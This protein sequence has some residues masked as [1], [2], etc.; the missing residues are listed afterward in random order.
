MEGQLKLPRLL[1]EGCVLQQGEKTRVWGWCRRNALVTVTLNG[2]RE[3]AYGD[4]GGGFEVFFRDLC[5]GGPYSLR[6]D[7]DQEDFLEVKTLWV[8]EVFVCGGQSNM[9]L[10]MRRV[11]ERFPEELLHGGDPEV[12]IYKVMETSEFSVPLCDHNDARWVVCRRDELEELSAVS[13]YLGKYL[14]Q[15][16]KVPIGIINLSLGG[17]PAEAWTSPEGLKEFGELLA[18][19]KKYEDHTFR[20]T[21]LNQQKEREQEWYDLLEKQEG[22]SRSAPWRPFRLPGCLCDI[23]LMAFSGCVWLKRE[24]FVP[25]ELAG[26]PC[27]LKFG[28]MA[29]SDTI[30]INGKLVGETG[31]R[32]PPR[33][34]QVPEG[35]LKA[36]KN[37]ICLRLVC[38]EGDGRITPGKQ[39]CLQWDQPQQKPDPDPGRAKGAAL[40]DTSCGTPSRI[41][42]TGLW[43]CQVRAVCSPAPKPEFFNRRPTGL[44]HGMVSPCL[45]YTVKGVVWYQGESNDSRPVLY[46][47]LLKA[48]I[49]DWRSQW[50]Q[51]NLPFVLVQLPC[52]G[53]DIAPYP[54]WPHIREAQ[55]KAGQLPMT[56][57][58]VNLDLG[59]ENDLHPL[60]KKNVAYRIFLAIQR[61]FY[62]E[63]VAAV[64]P[65]VKGWIKKDN[66][67]LLEFSPEDQGS[68]LTLDRQKPGEF[69]LAGPD[70]IFYPAQAEL[71]P[72]EED[73][74][75]A[76]SA[77]QLLL[78]SKEVKNPCHVRYAWSN[79]PKKGLICNESG[80]LTGPFEINMEE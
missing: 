74:P 36:G 4:S 38:T 39:Y 45:P 17:T 59:E 34:Y 66:S 43:E 64:G 26:K 42:L 68:V 60:D 52:C 49:C 80:L 72:K 51:E 1:G 57:L 9:E 70:K 14:R 8:G 21:L 44:F 33:I 27:I 54:A 2:R 63:P 41:D 5:P 16:K 12:H 31:Y 77:V 15:W 62:G 19:R 30:Y 65:R 61:L 79:V 73:F 18:V 69:E 25:K 10:P 7:T 3:Q 78:T 46:E 71:E 55:R 29:D 76:S 53:V 23:G 20:M 48:M 24:F 6:I 28:T 67:V 56:A 32:Y 50:K 40:E 13:Y 35:V 75:A 47:K 11:R 22:E 37:E 58:T